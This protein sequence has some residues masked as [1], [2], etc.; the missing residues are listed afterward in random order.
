M[1]KMSEAL[2]SYKYTGKMRFVISEMMLSSWG[3][4][5]VMR[6]WSIPETATELR[7]TFSRLMGPARKDWFQ[8]KQQEKPLTCGLG[9]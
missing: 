7:G 2:Q 9:M 6:V 3:C 8:N 1:Y 5:S 4:S